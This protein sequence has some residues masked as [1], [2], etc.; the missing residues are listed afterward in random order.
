MFAKSPPARDDSDMVGTFPILLKCITLACL[1]LVTAMITHTKK[2][3]GG[4]WGGGGW[5]NY[6]EERSSEQANKQRNKQ[7]N[8]EQARPAW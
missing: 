8:T 5:V 4:G 2:R 6:R 7:S 3:N 1:S